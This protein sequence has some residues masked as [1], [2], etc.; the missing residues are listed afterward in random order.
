MFTTEVNLLSGSPE[1]FHVI[2]L[3]DGVISEERLYH[4]ELS[5]LCLHDLCRWSEGI[6][7]SEGISL[8]IG[9][10]DGEPIPS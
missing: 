1:R 10:F 2:Y 7:P 6:P 8:P 5:Y 4:A 3:E 9:W